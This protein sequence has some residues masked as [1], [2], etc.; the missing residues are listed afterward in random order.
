MAARYLTRRAPAGVRKTFRAPD[1]IYIILFLMTLALALGANAHFNRHHSR[2][3]AGSLLA[4]V[5]VASYFPSFGARLVS[6]EALRGRP[7]PPFR[8]KHSVPRPHFHTFI[9][10]AYE[11]SRRSCGKWADGYT[12][13][14][15]RPKEGRTIAVDKRIIPLGSRVWIEG[16]GWRVAEDVGGAI[17]GRRIDIFFRTIR[18]CKRFGRRKLRVRWIPPRVKLAR[19]EK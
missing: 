12:A 6:R 14:M 9:V 19:R 13:T 8:V 11:A 4:R 16:L 18:R 10:T 1:T 2:P 15:T 3:G 17:K 5:P 7:F